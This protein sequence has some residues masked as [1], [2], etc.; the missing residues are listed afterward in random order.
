MIAINPQHIHGRWAGGAALDFHTIRST[1]IGYDQFGHMRFETE[2]PPIAQLLYE[3]KYQT[4]PEA[5]EGI[6]NAAAN[7]LRPYVQQLRFDI[8]IPVPPSSARAIQP[9]LLLA[10]GIGSSLGLPVVN[11][12]TTT[13]Q[14]TQLKGVTNPEQ[15]RELV[16]GLY[17][18]D[19]RHTA[20]KTV[21]LFDDLYRSGTTMNEISDI[22]V[23]QGGVSTI[24]AMTITKTRSNQ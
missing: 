15:R 20:G 4:N 22:L 17:T 8:I 7:Y 2:R 13:R 6:I 14:P 18:V 21:L 16:A 1:P 10:Q 5:A 19:P 23:R 3:L 9:V 24:Y 11:C 12:I